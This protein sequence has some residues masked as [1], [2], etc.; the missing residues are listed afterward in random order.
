[1]IRRLRKHFLKLFVAWVVLTAVLAFFVLRSE[2]VADKVYHHILA[3]L[4]EN[5]QSKV[6]MGRPEVSWLGGS[7]YIKDVSIR[8]GYGKEKREFISAKG[9]RVSLLPWWNIFNREIGIRSVRLE[10]PVVYL[11][12]EK[13]K[14]ANLPSLDFLKGEKGPF[15]FS[16]GEVRVSNGKMALDYPEKGADMLFSKIDVRIRPDIDK[17]HYGFF[18][19]DAAADIKFKELAE[20]IL[21]L[22]GDFSITPEHLTLIKG[23]V[24]VPEGSMSAEGFY[25]DFATSKWNAKVS[26]ASD[27][28]VLKKAVRGQ[29]AKVVDT[30]EKLGL[31]GRADLSAAIDGDRSGFNAEARFKSKGI[32]LSGIK[33]SDVASNISIRFKAGQKKIEVSPISAGIFGGALK[34][35]IGFDLGEG[36]GFIGKL[37]IENIGIRELSN[38]LPAT[39][40]SPLPG[41]GGRVSGDI[42]ISGSLTRE[43]EV[44]GS[45]A[46]Q[47]KGLEV[48][49]G[50]NLAVKA[51]AAGIKARI[52]YA[53]GATNINYFVMETPSSTV[54][55]SGGI[56]DGRMSL[57]TMVNS[58]DLS[59]LTKRIKGRGMLKGRVSG[60]ISD[61]GVDGSLD[62]AGVS[63]N[64][65][66]ADAISGNISFK[67]RTV[68]TT[69]LLLRHGGSNISL[70]G[71]LPLSKEVP[72]LDVMVEVKKGRLEDLISM[73]GTEMQARGEVSLR[74]TVKNTIS[75]PEGE[76]SVTG[77]GMNIK[78]EEIDSIA[79]EGLL[80][81]G[82]FR[83]KKCEASRE[84]ERLTING[85]IDISGD[86]SINVSSSPL[87]LGN[88]YAVKKNRLPLRGA[89]GVN[90]QITGNIKNPSFKGKGALSGIVY[91]DMR[92]GSGDVDIT[93][94]DRALTASGALFG[95][96]LKGTL[97]LE[98]EK[99]F[100]VSLDAKD[101]S[102]GQFFE[103]KAN[104]EGLTGELSGRIEADGELS[105]LG[106][107]SAKAYISEFQMARDPF[108][109]KNAK[110]IE[111][112]LRNGKV[113]LK[114]FQLSGRG[115][116]VDA[117][118]WIGIDGGTNLE[119][120]G[121]LD[122]S[123]LELF[124]G[125]IK[126]GEG[127]ADVALTISGKPSKIEGKVVVRDGTIGVK[128]FDP[129][130]HGVS[131][132]ISL[133]KGALIVES[134][135]GR[136]GEGRF[137][138]EG[139]V[140]MAGL[141]LK[142][143][144]MA[145]DVTGVRLA[146]PK[147]LQSE[148]EGSLR[149]TGDYPSLL[150]SGEM[151]VVKARYSERMDWAAFLPSFRERLREPGARKEGEGALKM[152]INFKADRNLIF[153]N[154]IGT[155]EL[156]GEIR[157]KGDTARLGV[158]GAVEVITGKVFYKEHEFNINSGI[159]EFPDPKKVEP[160]FDF[161]A[162]GKIRD[163]TI[164][165]LA[166]GSINDLKVTMTS[167]PSLSELDIA[168]LLSFGLT[169]E[170]FQ[171]RGGGA[172]VYGAVSILSREVEDRFKD[173]IGFD[174]FH[175]DPYYS[176]VTGT[177][178][179][180]LTVGK[181]LSD[182]MLLIY[183]RGLSG[184]GEQEV[185][186]EYKLY[187][188]FSLLGGW[189]SFGAS[190]SG[191]LGADMKFRF[192][193]R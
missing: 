107:V 147:W 148:V 51:P 38:S 144:D 41:A 43:P 173:Y 16:L 95:A 86:M 97:S 139:T 165:I 22:K 50:E 17:G 134:L 93:V 100:S 172:P 104:F 7:W 49:H 44:V 145:F 42:D 109:L 98:G 20:K 1:M 82:K 70:K 128:G 141:G 119:V 191:Y 151:N 14:I 18:L 106:D 177:S 53:A 30:I 73:T 163:Y 188:N 37:H 24:A 48:L 132:N 101:L 69:G 83:I 102:L 152:D 72:G 15:K 167:S 138:M 187:R 143:T 34:G 64:G 113:I 103:G 75:A 178:E 110:E 126:K 155:G 57:E 60:T 160:L 5:L 21:S 13:G 90:G 89:V 3:Y 176:K 182:E 190:H 169:V 79:I 174:R 140:E 99:P 125:I 124:T 157:L 77:S 67:G 161:T 131:G 183:S 108:L 27:L 92:L 94:A 12:V 23:F 25:M 58:S 87:S 120:T 175:I 81:K 36:K 105:R 63:W 66:H 10:D 59:E 114:T 116:Q 26:A 168:S 153:E 127:I 121:N 130:F 184:T 96:A 45:S 35:K 6:E 39:R 78:G 32:E 170:E 29:G 123:M 71:K 117:S 122:F 85:D 129:L 118:G 112:E 19:K 11:R 180:K 156:K 33:I 150:L 111:V 179:P 9:V 84:G 55:V 189:S 91:K 171:K 65:Y 47:I 135:A 2:F 68:S 80:K 164:Q 76:I 28:S 142:R 4:E 8:P 54:S 166:Q 61:P 146:Y 62:L 46:L 185:Q 137:K 181:E 158:V 31:K 56:A 159:I 115:T 136:L 88:L 40:Q 193:F 52:S 154:N 162:E 149:L 133:R 74:G 192:E 186:M